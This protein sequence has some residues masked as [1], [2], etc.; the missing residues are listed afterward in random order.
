MIQFDIITI[1]PHIF[2]SYLK[3]SFI[4]KARESGKISVDIHD[5][6]KFADDPHK[7]VDDRPYGGGLGMVL[8]IEPIYRAVQSLKSKF[9]NQNLKIILFTP[10]GKKFN[11][12]VAYKL[13]KLDRIIMICGRYEG[14]DERVA[15]K[16]A[17][18]EI[19]IGD[20]DLMGGELPAMVAIETITRLIP[21]L[22]G[23]PEFLKERITKSKGFLEYPQYTRPEI[24]SPK[25]KIE[26]KVPKLFLSGHHKKIEEWRKKHG[27]A[28]EK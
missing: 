8:K 5:L 2:D 28:I 4:K 7:S 26:W 11:Q 20:Y 1:F 24:F 12:Q 19:S 27:K 14:V 18:M 22:L 6:R 25:K 9:K 21:G 16:L 15:K 13:S 17:D 10:R 3:E 23:K